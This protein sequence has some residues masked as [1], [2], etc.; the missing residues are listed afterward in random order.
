M[1]WNPKLFSLVATS[2]MFDGMLVTYYAET[3]KNSYCL[4]NNEGLVTL[5]REK[6]QISTISTNGIHFWNE[7]KAFVSSAEN[8]IE[9]NDRA[10]NGEFY[11][12]P[13]YNYLIKRGLKIGIF[14]IPNEQHNAVGIPED[15]KSYL[16]KNATL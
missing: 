11:V 1:S 4:I 2:G 16:E 15:L 3:D 13:S 6:E 12:A 7:G 5:V 14:H 10:P 8:M 9:A